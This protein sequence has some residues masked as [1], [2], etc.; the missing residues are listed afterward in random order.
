[1]NEFEEGQDLLLRLS[2]VRRA[3]LD[4]QHQ[5]AVN[6]SILS[7]SGEITKAAAVRHRIARDLERFDQ[8]WTLAIKEAIEP[9]SEFFRS[10]NVSAC[11]YSRT[12]CEALL[13]AIDRV[14]RR[15]INK[16]DA[17]S[18]LRVQVSNQQ[19]LDAAIESEFRSAFYAHHRFPVSPVTSADCD[20]IRDIA[21]EAIVDAEAVFLEIC[22][23]AS[24]DPERLQR[25]ASNLKGLQQRWSA[26][27]NVET[28]AFY[29][30]HNDV[31]SDDDFATHAEM[32][33][34][35]LAGGAL[36]A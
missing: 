3:A 33:V 27:W 25:L 17:L 5:F 32:A 23:L 20:R 8:C 31:A 9:H 24:E 6:W 21:L 29:V 34:R 19:D 28:K 14:A 1:M 12:I 7:E 36:A 26:I 30:E 13:S 35:R 4:C 16:P 2:A 15:E 10:H 11:A 22:V 18:E